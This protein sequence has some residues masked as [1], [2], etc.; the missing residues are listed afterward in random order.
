MDLPVIAPD[1]SVVICAYTESR[2]RELTEAVESMHRQ[3]LAPR[4]IYV[5][6][7]HNPALLERARATLP[8]VGGGRE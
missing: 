6:V 1:I 7:D 4:E 5:V 3:T 2:W 8:G